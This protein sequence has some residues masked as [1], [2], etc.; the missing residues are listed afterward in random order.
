MHTQILSFI[1]D[2]LRN[3]SYHLWGG[4]LFGGISLVERRGTNRPVNPKRQVDLT[5]VL[6]SI[7]EPALIIDCDRRVIDANS[8]AAQL[9][10]RTREELLDADWS[11][12]AGLLSSS[13][14][15]NPQGALD[16]ALQGTAVR[17]EKRLVHDSENRELEL[18]VSATPMRDEHDCV[19][20]A[21]VIARDITELTSL[22]RRIGDVER[23]LA[24][25]QMAA[26]LA[27]D[28]NNIL[29]SIGQAAYILG[30]GAKEQSDK[31]RRSYIGIIQNAVHRG[32]E[33]VANVREY[34]RTGSGLREP[35]DVRLLLEEALEL[36]RPLFERARIRVRAELHEV[37]RTLANAADM[38]RVFTNVIINGIEAMPQGG[39]MSVACY[40]ENDRIIA[41]VADTGP[42]IAPENR[43]KVFYPYFT[44]KKAGTG[45]GLSGAQR[46]LRAQGGNIGFRTETGKGTTFIITLPAAAKGPA[47]GAI[48][49]RQRK[50]AA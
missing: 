6:Q 29:T 7:P 4:L 43:R 40:D 46:T 28:L 3:P 32:A 14:D 27:H 11:Q 49:A 44:T 26:A 41:T 23:H 18:L 12:F 13:D 34:M 2:S 45:L 42:G 1:S 36:T 8:A 31:E 20:A 16:R 21:L 15:A 47:P 33:I 22:Q 10:C 48:S 37:P 39:E 17:A 25:G 5:T 9:L 19:V 24:I 50:P 35:V 30:S 38:R